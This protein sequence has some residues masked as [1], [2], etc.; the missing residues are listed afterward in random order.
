MTVPTAVSGQSD[1]LLSPEDGTSRFSAEYNPRVTALANGGFVAL[2]SDFLPQT[3]G[4]APPTYPY[5]IDA[6]G[7][8]MTMLRRFGPDGAALGPAIPVSTDLTGTFD[9]AGV[10]TLSNGNVIA[11]WGV[12][13]GTTASRIGAIV[14]DPATGAVIGSEIAVAT[15][16][17]FA[18]GVSFHQ[19]V[20]LSGGRAGLLFIDGAGTD[21]LRLA[22]IEA[23]GSLGAI[24]TL[25]S[26]TG[27]AAWVPAI[28]VNDAVAGL[29]GPNTD[30]IA[31][32]TTTFVGFTSQYR[33]EFFRPDGTSAGL[34]ILAIGDTGGRIPVLAA[35]PDGGVAAAW[36]TD[37]AG[38]MR[39]VKTDAAGVQV[40]GPIDVVFPVTSF[41]A[42][43]LIALPDGGLILTTAGDPPAPGF[44]SDAY[45][46][47]IAP[48]GTLDGGVFRIDAAPSGQQGRTQ[49][50]VAGDGSLVAVFEDTRNPF[51]YAIRAAR[52]DLDL[53]DPDQTLAGG[54]GPDSL[55]GR[56]GDDS[57]TG[58]RGADTLSGAD[59]A[60]TVNGGAGND[61]LG[62]G[63]G[64]DRLA[65]GS[66][67]DTLSGGAGADILLGGLGNDRFVFGPGDAGATD[68]IRDWNAGDLIDLTA[69]GPLDFV[70]ASGLPGG[71][72]VA[73]VRV[74]VKVGVTLVQIDGIDAD[75]TPDLVIRISGAP[76]LAQT[77]FVLA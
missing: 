50:A 31:A 33:V 32:V 23:D 73:A 45:G 28:G 65:G 40:G 57:I 8:Q 63:A 4:S 18:E 14:I 10:V 29:T 75:A 66:G 42:H 12:A 56:G 54:T 37:A 55:A 26:N 69:F 52:F 53:A 58:G 1:L 5:G 43:D 41:G 49:L 77:D 15:G 36:S 3:A 59:G 71:D 11:G 38:G 48:D 44:D 64:A 67:D 30:V 6:D 20:A 72:G 2:W 16:G 70:G 62:G 13:V 34:P 51:D 21:R 68:R 7:G 24:S 61:V 27:G 60:D 17:A 74:T 22:V 39:V 35:L 25:R 9:G 47:R 76:A 46:Q 19:V